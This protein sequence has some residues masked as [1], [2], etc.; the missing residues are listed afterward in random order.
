MTKKKDK[1]KVQPLTSEIGMLRALANQM[2]GRAATATLAGQ[3]YGGERKLYDALGYKHSPDF[4]DFYNCYNRQDIARRVIKA[5]VNASWRKKPNIE[6]NVEKTAGKPGERTEFETAWDTLVREL[7]VF[8]YFLRIDRLA[9]IGEFGALFLGFDD[10]GDL[11]KEV[12]RGNLIYL[13]PYN[14]GS[15]TV[16][17]WQE[18]IKDPRYGQPEIYKVK[19]AMPGSSTGGEDKQVHWTRMLHVAEEAEE[20][21]VI[22]TPR[23][24]PIYNRLQDLEKVAGGSAEMF[25]RGAF[26]GYGLKADPEFEFGKDDME[27]LEE[28]I[29]KF[30][31]DLQRY[32]RLVGVDVKELASQV[33]D[34][35]GHADI[36]F[37]LI[38]AATGIPKRILTGT[39][40]GE[41]ASIMDERNWNTFVDARRDDHCESL[42][43][44]PFISRLVHVKAMPEPG[45]GG[46]TVEWEDLSSP[47]EKE[48]AEVIKLRA[49][50]L[51]K[52]VGTPGME[53]L[54]PWPVFLKREMG[55]TDEEIKKIEEV[56][57][58]GELDAEVAAAEAA[59]V[60][61]Q[62]EKDMRDAGWTAPQLLAP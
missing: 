4:T 2:I 8:H 22:G 15:L 34:P 62:I 1:S 43:L 9:G 37:Q 41:L 10:G 24:R 50:A 55:Y 52:Y 6:E 59:E 23:L 17:K 45:E 19:M 18:D 47:T 21:D 39:E 58:D 5:P 36:L 7:R 16:D 51:A 53:M 3:S 44:R 48:R 20:N 40:R 13:M 30:V 56:Q 49:E 29:T 61:R 46:Y 57:T 54:M 60:R 14:Q 38:S 42:I 35:K 27:A 31:H 32:I 28:E 25:W 11:G 12:T 26:P 33:A